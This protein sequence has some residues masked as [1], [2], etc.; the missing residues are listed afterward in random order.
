MRYYKVYAE[1][2]RKP[3]GGGVNEISKDEA[4]A[5]ISDS[6]EFNSEQHMVDDIEYAYAYAMEVVEG[7]D[8]FE[9]GDFAIMKSDTIPERGN[10]YDFTIARRM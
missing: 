6:L 2:V 5:L 9:C 1:C 7:G 8:I 10:R 3:L 4:L